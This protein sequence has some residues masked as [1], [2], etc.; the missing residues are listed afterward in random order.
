MAE[1]FARDSFPVICFGRKEMASKNKTA[2][3]LT[4][5]STVSIL[6]LPDMAKDPS[7]TDGSS[8]KTAASEGTQALQLRG[9]LRKVGIMNR[10]D[11]VDLHEL[12]N[13]ERA[14]FPHEGTK[15]LFFNVASMEV[16]RRM[17]LVGE[18]NHH[19]REVSK[20]LGHTKFSKCNIESS[21]PRPATPRDMSDHVRVD[22]YLIMLGYNCICCDCLMRSLLDATHTHTHTARTVYLYVTVSVVVVACVCLCVCVCTCARLRTVRACA[23][24]FVC[25]Y[26]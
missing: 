19:T 6:R 10:L 1:K 17:F 26:V 2:A 25:L 7:T 5:V 11:Y 18:R 3:A 8:A 22:P 4:M 13:N 24:M 15:P 21:R 16:L 14:R 12:E 23:C 20:M 9:V